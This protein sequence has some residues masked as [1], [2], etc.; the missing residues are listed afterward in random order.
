MKIFG[1]IMGL[2]L[3][4][5]AQAQTNFIG[6][7]QF[8]SNGNTYNV[9]YEPNTWLYVENGMNFMRNTNQVID[10]QYWNN[11][12]VNVNTSK[13]RIESLVLNILPS[14]RKRVF[15][16]NEE[17]LEMGI[18]IGGDNKI[19]EII[20]SLSPQTILTRDEIYQIETTLKN[21]EVIMDNR[22]PCSF[23]WLHFRTKIRLW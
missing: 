21:K 4:I 5:E 20:F 18:V 11:F 14:S 22:Y 1:I 19:K 9:D 8:T 10:C 16:A 2:L 15:A 13:S 7:N 12:P 3:C 17:Y 23:N 6:I